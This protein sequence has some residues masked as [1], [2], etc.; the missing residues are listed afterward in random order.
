MTPD[1]E[2]AGVAKRFGSTTA[3]DDFHW[4]GGSGVV[5]LLGPNGAGKTTLLRMLATVLAPDHGTI[6][7]HGLDPARS[8]DR[9]AIRRLLGY[10][11]QDTGLYPCFSAFDLVDYVAVLKEI[12]NPTTRHDQVHE[13]LCAV[14]LEDQMHRRIRTLSGGTKRRVAIAAAIVGEP[15]LLVLDEPS[16]GLD[17]DQRLRLRDVVSRA[18]RHGTVVVSTH[19]TDEAAALCQTVLVLDGG[20]LCFAGTPRELASMAAGRVWVDDHPHPNAIRTWVTGEGLVR[21]IGTPPQG[22]QLVEPNIDDGYLFATSN[23]ATP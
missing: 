22:A 3:L 10:L 7:I 12:A 15:R 5:G 6:R 19:Q 4:S 18:G 21:S 1:L 9:L 14:G 16:A 20:R 23:A 17:P 2:L 8:G 13:A 11:P